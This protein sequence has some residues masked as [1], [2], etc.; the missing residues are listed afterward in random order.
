MPKTVHFHES[1]L[2]AFVEGNEYSSESGVDSARS[3]EGSMVSGPETRDNSGPSSRVENC[4][5]E[6]RVD[7]E[8]GLLKQLYIEHNI[9]SDN[10]RRK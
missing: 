5:L 8:E 3:S 6:E 1:T 7:E 10:D 4:E 2:S 9:D